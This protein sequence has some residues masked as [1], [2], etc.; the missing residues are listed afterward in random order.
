MIMRIATFNIR[1]I[2][3]RAKINLE[4]DCQKYHLD[5]LALQETKSPLTEWTSKNGFQFHS[6]E[7]KQR[8]YGQGFAFGPR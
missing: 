5:I 1:G 2:K 4:Y 7:D 6:L 8:H 3:E